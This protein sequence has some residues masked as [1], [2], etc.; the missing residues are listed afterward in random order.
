MR[1]PGDILRDSSRDWW[2]VLTP[3]CDFEQKK[4][5]FVL[6]AH[7]GPLE[8]H[9][10]Y[11]G[12]TAARSKGNTAK[13]EW[14]ELCKDVL[15][16]TQGRYHYLPA[17]RD[18]PDLV[19]DLENVRS[20]TADTLETMD[21]IA[22]LVSPFS[23]ALLIQHSHFRGRIGVPDLDAKIIKQRLEAASTSAL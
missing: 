18:I 5:K 21:P 3:A 23:E 12:W 9:D 19:I 13:G 11:L 16:A 2:V 7:A 15:M 20:V 17:F 4:F 6:L 22:S 10:K 14:N 1:A 8:A